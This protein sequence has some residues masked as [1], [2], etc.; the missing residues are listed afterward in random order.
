[1][2]NQTEPIVGSSPDG[3]ALNDPDELCDAARVLRDVSAGSASVHDSDVWTQEFWEDL[4]VAET[5]A[6][7]ALDA[8]WEAS[9]SGSACACGVCITRLVLEV[10]MPVITGHVESVT[11]S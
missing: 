3:A 6:Q 1:M 2:Q 9:S 7:D 10:V 11:G 8:L 5:H 4:S